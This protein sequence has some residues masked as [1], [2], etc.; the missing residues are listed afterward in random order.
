[1]SAIEPSWPSSCTASFRGAGHVYATLRNPPDRRVT[2]DAQRFDPADESRLYPTF[3]CRNCGQEHHPATIVEEAGQLRV[4]PRSIDETPLDDPSTSDRPGYVMPQPDD[5]AFGF[6]GAREDYPEEWT[7]TTRKGVLRLRQDRRRSAAEL[8]AVDPGGAISTTGRPVWFLPGKFRFCPASLHQPAGQAREINKLAGLSAEGRSS[9]TT[10]LVSSALRWMNTSSESLPPDRRKILAFTDNRQDAALQAGHFNDFLFVSL[11]RAAIL[12]AVR[13]A[14]TEGLS[15]A[16]FGR[17]VQQ[18]LGF[19]AANRERRKEWMIDPEA[20]GVGQS[21]AE[22][23]LSRVLAHRVWAD[24]RR[25]WR[26][27]NPSLEELGM[28]RAEYVALDDLAAD[29]NA[30]VGAPDELRLASPETRRQALL[31]VL[32]HLRKGLAITAEA[33]EPAM[34]EIIANEARQRLRE[35]WSIS[36]QESPRVAGGADYRRPPAKRSRC[37]R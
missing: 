7:E 32:E 23:T 5:P 29:D 10:L 1:V 18:E 17:A 6:G 30:F 28:I 31:V 27:T 24:Q 16:Y 26:F 4:L 25:G 11:L 8:L 33:L 9:A 14:G 13:E 12:A 34:V 21:D 15:D 19:T 22:G 20:R 36:Q 2:L 37:P 3:F 35:P